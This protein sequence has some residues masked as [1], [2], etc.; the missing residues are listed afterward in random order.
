[1][2]VA[3]GRR[4]RQVG[5]PR[6][7]GEALGT[8]PIAVPAHACKE[9]W[10]AAQSH[11]P[12]SCPADARC[13]RPSHSSGVGGRAGGAVGRRLLPP[14]RGLPPGVPRVWDHAGGAGEQERCSSAASFTLAL[15]LDHLA[16]PPSLPAAPSRSTRPRGS[17]GAPAWTSCTPSGASACSR[18][19]Q[20]GASLLEGRSCKRWPER[21]GSLQTWPFVSP[22]TLS[23]SSSFCRHHS[24]HVLRLPAA[25]R[26]APRVRS[27]AAGARPRRPPRGQRGLMCVAE[28]TW[29][30]PSCSEPAPA[31]CCSCVD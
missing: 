6:Q 7:P 3:L 22:S 18:A 23:S 5:T 4:G 19:M 31:A 15:A 8:P 14:A 24:R 10:P 13:Q 21:R 16:K 28:R 29:A 12:L 17:S 20:V 25:R 26:L 1:M 30:P 9:R 11:L 27:Q 2:A